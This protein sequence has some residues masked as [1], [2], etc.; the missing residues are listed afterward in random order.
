METG[1]NRGLGWIDFPLVSREIKKTFWIIFWRPGGIVFIRPILLQ[2]NR[3]LVAGIFAG[4]QPPRD[5]H[6]GRKC[7][8]NSGPVAAARRREDSEATGGLEVHQQ[9]LRT[10]SGL[11]A[12]GAKGWTQF[13]FIR[14][15][16]SS[17]VAG[18]V[19]LRASGTR[20][21]CWHNRCY[22]ELTGPQPSRANC[23][24]LR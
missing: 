12:S 11:A 20:V 4:L 6:A 23:Y 17:L 21:A 2:P 16:L 24:D 19:A 7:F 14:G 10:V 15:F 13:A 9:M 3:S 8:A 1:K 18:F 5:S 22:A